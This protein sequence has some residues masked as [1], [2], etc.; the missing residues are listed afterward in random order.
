MVLKRSKGGAPT[1]A[2]GFQSGWGHT[3]FSRV[4]L[5]LHTVPATSSCCI[6]APQSLSQRP[7]LPALELAEASHAVD[8]SKGER[9][10]AQTNA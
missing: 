4:Q 9:A 3:R 8:E 6:A 2:T 7:R 10:G 1:G 5:Q